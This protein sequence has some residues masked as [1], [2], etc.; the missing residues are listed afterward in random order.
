MQLTES[1]EWSKGVY[2]K[3]HE[4]LT[5]YFHMI[6]GLAP[7]VYAM[8][9]SGAKSIKKTPYEIVF[10]QKPCFNFEMWK[11]LSEFGIEDEEKLA[12]GYIDALNEGKIFFYEVFVKVSI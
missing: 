9:T 7:V 6:L 10:G 1:S 3:F 2:N 5:Y 11:L 12:Q 4:L 8:N